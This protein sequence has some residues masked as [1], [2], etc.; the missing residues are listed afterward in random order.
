ARRVTCTAATES[1][2]NITSCAT[3]RTWR[4]SIPMRARTTY[5]P[6]F[7]AGHKPASRRSTRPPPFKRLGTAQDE[8]ET[9]GRVLNEVSPE[10]ALSAACGRRHGRSGND[11]RA[12]G[13][14][15]RQG[16][17]QQEARHVERSGISATVV[18]ERK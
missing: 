11:R 5:T 6:S 1:R 2:S 13:R 3:P 7:S 4:P 15:A 14:G 8:T 17:G 12:G 10:E 18:P 16:D 9:R